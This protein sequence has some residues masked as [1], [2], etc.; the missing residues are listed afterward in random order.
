M[1]ARLPSVA[2]WLLVALQ[3]AIPA[4]YYLRRDRS[5]DERFSWRMFSAVRLKH[6]SVSAFDGESDAQ[7][8]TLS[9]AVHASWVRSMS[10]GRERV[11]ERFLATR[12]AMPDVRIAVL[13]RRCKWPSGRPLPSEKYR[14]DCALQ[15][16]AVTR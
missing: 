8:V 9:S 16:L 4:A 13:E 7:P 2:L 3:V 5:D 14:F 15:R 12:C 11:I 10:R 6:C 1:R